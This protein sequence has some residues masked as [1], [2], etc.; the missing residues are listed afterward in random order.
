MN[1]HKQELPSGF[2]FE[3]EIM[4]RIHKM[5]QSSDDENLLESNVTP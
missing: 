3:T 4:I 2:Q 1:R 5:S